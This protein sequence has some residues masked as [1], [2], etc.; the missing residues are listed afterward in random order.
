[1]GIKQNVI[2]DLEE[3]QKLGLCDSGLIE[4]V[5]GGNFDDDIEENDNLKVSDLSDLIIQLGAFK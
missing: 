1:M 2:K 4:R 3:L 5:K